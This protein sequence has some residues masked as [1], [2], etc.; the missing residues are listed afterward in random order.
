MT[1][2]STLK[3]LRVDIVKRCEAKNRTAFGDILGQV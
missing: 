2:P 3:I 1:P